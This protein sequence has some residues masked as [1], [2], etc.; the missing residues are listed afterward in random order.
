[1]VIN[2][3][4]EDEMVSPPHTFKSLNIVHV[5]TLLIKP[6][7]NIH[8]VFALC[9]KLHGSAMSVEKKSLYGEQ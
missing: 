1:M 5:N 9:C 8:V 4:E 7:P 3:G 6:A 2:V